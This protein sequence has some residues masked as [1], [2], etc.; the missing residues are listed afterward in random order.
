L[1]RT[2]SKIPILSFFSGA[3]F[4]DIGFLKSGFQIVWHN[5]YNPSFV[6]AFECGMSSLGYKGRS[7][8]VQNTSSIVEIGPNQILKEA[9]PGKSK[10][11][12]FGM[13]G[14]PPCPDFSVGGKN[15]GSNGDNGK[16]S[17]VYINRIL[18]INP[19]FFV[20]ENVPGLFRTKKHRDFLVKLMEKLKD[21][22]VL[23]VNILNCLDFGVPQDRE[24]VFFVGVQRKWL[25]KRIGKKK[26][27]SIQNTDE[28]IANISKLKPA[29]FFKT[30][31]H[32]FPWPT[33]PEFNDAKKRFAWPSANVEYNETPIKPDCPE[34]LMV[35]TYICNDWVQDLPNGKEAFNPKSPKFK[36]TKEGDV[37][38]KSFKKLHRFRYS[39]AVAYGNNEV[40]LHPVYDRRLTVREALMLQSVPNEYVL[41]EDL[42]LSAKFKTIGNGVPV[43]LAEALSLEIIKMFQKEELHEAI[44]FN[45]RP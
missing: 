31:S 11:E 25:H 22:Y 2:N 14:G 24:R 40:H 8:K 13:I 9:F 12:L 19:T 44:R 35:G 21:H 16:L 7:A 27:S 1:N 6:K 17:E 39:P 38:R 33:N 45:A 29:V 3:G 43:K 10:P 20:F 18:E 37:S 23:D 42:T 32:W 41:P 28:F 30:I 15:K 34:E 5:E 4:M 36:T 26:T